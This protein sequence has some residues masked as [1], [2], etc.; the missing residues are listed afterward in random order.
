M[1]RAGGIVSLTVI[2][3]VIALATP[4]DSPVGLGQQDERRAQSAARAEFA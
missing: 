2:A 4:F 3:V 1:R